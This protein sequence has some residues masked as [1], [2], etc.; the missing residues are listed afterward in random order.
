MRPLGTPYRIF[1]GLNQLKCCPQ[2]VNGSCHCRTVDNVQNQQRNYEMHPET[3][4]RGV[5]INPHNFQCG[6]GA[7]G[8]IYVR[9]LFTFLLK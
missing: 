7:R 8:R 6:V 1:I 4:P 9:L 2:L 3:L 5:G